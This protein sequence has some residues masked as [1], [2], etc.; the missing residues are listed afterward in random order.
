MAEIVFF[1]LWEHATLPPEQIDHPLALGKSRSAEVIKHMQL[2]RRKLHSHVGTSPDFGLK[3]GWKQIRGEMIELVFDAD[4]V[5]QCMTYG[6]MTDT[7]SWQVESAITVEA[8]VTAPQAT[9]GEMPLLLRGRALQMFATLPNFVNMGSFAPREDVPPLWDIRGR[10]YDKWITLAT[11]LPRATLSA[12]FVLKANKVRF[13]SR[14][15]IDYCLTKLSIA[16]PACYGPVEYG[17]DPA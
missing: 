11:L 5:W 17:A 6:Q 15:E 13:E 8:G 7:L 1:D 16:T 14:F 12:D 4:D 10:E 2:P 3:V 9:A